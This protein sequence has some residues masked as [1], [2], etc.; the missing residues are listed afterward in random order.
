M[1]EVRDLIKPDFEQM[2]SGMCTS[3]VTEVQ[4][5]ENGQRTGEIVGHKADFLLDNG[6]TITVKMPVLD[7]PS[8]QLKKEYALEFDKDKSTVYVSNGRLQ[9][10]LWAKSI[11]KIEMK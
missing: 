8:W 9:L 11:K 2:Q 6:V 3:D 7:K 4:K 1:A 5:Y 10:S